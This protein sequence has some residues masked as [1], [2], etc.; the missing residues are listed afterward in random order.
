MWRS[1]LVDISSGRYLT[2]RER[3]QAQVYAVSDLAV[4]KVDLAAFRTCAAHDMNDVWY[5]IYKRECRVMR[6]GI[7]KASRFEK[8]ERRAWF[9]RSRFLLYE[10]LVAV[11]CAVLKH[12]CSNTA[13][14]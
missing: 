10:V 5:T 6:C 7:M 9:P 14:D 13:R 2:T 4:A 1:R 12:A 8:R 11:H 3:I